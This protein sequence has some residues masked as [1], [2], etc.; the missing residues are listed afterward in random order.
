MIG[1]SDVPVTWNQ[2]SEIEM[3]LTPPDIRLV[4]QSWGMIAPDAG[5]I[6]DLFY[7]RLF[8]LDPGLRLLFPDD[9]H[10][11]GQK[12]TSMLGQ[13]VS[14]LERPHQMVAAVR[15]MG[16]R[17]AGYGV[18]REHYTAVREALLWTLALAL[19]AAFTPEVELAWF[20]LYNWLAETMQEKT[21][22]EGA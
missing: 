17:H 16:E 12:L 3:N 1:A 9:M 19:G 10:R 6:A 18:Q 5:D 14:G 8:E 21:A 20:K 15:Q 11:Q 2:E 13:A 22:H 4:Q 7:T